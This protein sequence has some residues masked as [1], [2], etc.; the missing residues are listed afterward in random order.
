MEYPFNHRGYRYN[1][2]ELR[3]F[4]AFK[5][6]GVIP[7]QAR[8]ESYAIDYAGDAYGIRALGHPVLWMRTRVRPS[9]P[10]NVYERPIAALLEVS[11]IA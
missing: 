11:R 6:A 9:C 7:R 2:T 10:P 8:P 3:D 4:R 1:A 5:R